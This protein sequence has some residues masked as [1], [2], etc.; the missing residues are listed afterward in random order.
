MRAAVYHG[1]GSVEVVERPTPVPAGDQVLIQVAVCGICGTDRHIYHGEYAA[2][3]PVVL[4]HEYSGV[5]AAVGP[6]VADLLPGTPVAVDPNIACRVCR[7][8]R[9][10]QPHLCSNLRALGVDLDGGFA[11]YTLAPRAQCFALPEG[12][13][14]LEGAM[15]EP[16]ACCVHG[17]DLAQ[18]RTGDTVVV[19]GGGAIG[20][21]LAQLARLQG[22]GRVVVSDPLAFRREMALRLGADAVVDPTAE[23][24]LAM[25]GAL[26]GGAD[27]AIEAV[28][29][30]STAAQAVAWAAPGATVLWFGVTPPGQVVAVEPNLVFQKELTILGAR[31][32][33]H[34]HAHAIA[35]LASGRLSVRPLIT[36]Q[37]PL[38]ALAELLARGPG[39]QIKTAITPNPGL[40]LT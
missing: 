30:T 38:E 5:V 16:V 35:L 33:P 23:D 11:E 34:T 15:A 26:E 19:I 6:G 27:V 2:R 28:G 4:G 29:A 20:L 18:V 7:P 8:C 24:P 37:A 36:Q 10:G 1:S 13:S 12:V 9:R 31:M 32:N 17:M 22:A 40:I 39:E 3:P 14:L 21:I 25:G